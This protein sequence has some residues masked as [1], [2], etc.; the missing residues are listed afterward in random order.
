MPCLTLNGVDALEIGAV[1]WATL[2]LPRSRLV[3][4]KVS[5]MISLRG[6]G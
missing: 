5:E 6:L 4:A 3:R 2:A 1:M